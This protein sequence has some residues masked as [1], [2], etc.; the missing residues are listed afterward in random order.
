MSN[1]CYFKTVYSYPPVSVILPMSLISAQFQDDFLFATVAANPSPMVELY[2]A[3][4]LHL[5]V[6]GGKC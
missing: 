4:K 1:S 6:R 3:A 2:V 5:E